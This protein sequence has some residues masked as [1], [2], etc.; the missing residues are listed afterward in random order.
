MKE[1]KRGSEG[2]WI[3]IP[4]ASG[5]VARS[6]RLDLPRHH[7]HHRRWLGG[8]QPGKTCLRLRRPDH[9]QI[10][11][12]RTLRNCISCTAEVGLSNFIPVVSMY[13][14]FILRIDTVHPW[15]VGSRLVIP[16]EGRSRQKTGVRPS[17]LR[18]ASRYTKQQQHRGQGLTS[19]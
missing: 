17:G 10:D 14:F 12:S 4:P 1:K 7:R 2:T 3:N 18:R 16:E 19:E 9:P 11:S 6:V 13:T 5:L 8:F 15:P